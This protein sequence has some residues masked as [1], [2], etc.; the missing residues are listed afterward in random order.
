[1]VIF[2]RATVA[3]ASILVE[4]VVINVALS[5]DNA[6]V[7]GMAAAGL[8]RKRRL[9]ALWIGIGVATALRLGFA[10]IATRLLEII[11]LTLAGGLLLLWVAWKLWRELHEDGSGAATGAPKR[12]AAAL[13][14]IVVADVSMSLD[15]ALGVAGA[16]LGHPMIL[17]IGLVIS[18]LLMGVAAALLAGLLQRYRWISYAGLLVV[19][20]VALKMI[21]SGA[22]AI[23]GALG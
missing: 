14:Q 21:W 6:I 12:F 13:R 2:D 18:V 8:P 7:V 10:L 22:H 1:M 9:Q 16:A 11:G 5:G 23:A 20:Y 19:V 4:V 15:N 3:A 17:A